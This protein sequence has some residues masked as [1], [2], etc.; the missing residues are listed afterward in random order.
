LITGSGAAGAGAAGV[1]AAGVGAV[2]VTGFVE[3]IDVS[4][5]C[6]GS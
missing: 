2:G 4:T 6:C 3:S 1:G 5:P